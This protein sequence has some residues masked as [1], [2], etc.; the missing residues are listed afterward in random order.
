MVRESRS[1]LNLLAIE[2]DIG[3]LTSEYEA[4]SIL[5]NIQGVCLLAQLSINFPDFLAEIDT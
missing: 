5:P 2:V 1:G 4:C 3:P